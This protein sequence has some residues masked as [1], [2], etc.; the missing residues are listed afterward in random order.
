MKKTISFFLVFIMTLGLFLNFFSSEAL[1]ANWDAWSEW[2]DN[3]VAGNSS[4][5]VETRPVVVGYNMVVYQTQEAAPPY[6]RNF[7]SFSVNGNY[8]AYGLRSSYQE[9]HW[10]TYF[11]KSYLD[12]ARKYY[13]GDYINIKPEAYGY[14]RDNATSYLDSNTG[15]PWFIQ[16]EDVKTQYRFRDL[17]VATTYTVIFYD[18]DGK[19]LKTQ[20]VEQGQSAL[21][22]TNPYRE[23]YTFTGWNTSYSN[24]QSN[25]NVYAQYT[26]NSKKQ[27]SVTFLDWDGS[28]L[29]TQV[30]E[31][32]QS[33]LPPTN[34]YREG[35][36]FTGWSTPYSNVQSNTN[37]Y[38]QYAENSKKQFTVTFLDWDRSVLKTQVVEQGQSALPPTNPYREGYTFTGWSTSYSNVLSD[39]IIY[40]RY[41]QNKQLRALF[42]PTV[43][44]FSF[45][46]SRTDLGFP[47]G[48]K[49]PLQLWIDVHGNVNGT[50]L[51]YTRGQ[52]IWGGSCFGF[53][54]ASEKFYN[55][56][57][58]PVSYGSQKTFDISAPRSQNH[59]VTQ[60]IERSQISWFLP[61]VAYV[62]FN[63]SSLISACENFA[64]SGNNPLILYIDAYA[65]SIEYCHAVVPWKV[66]H[67]GND[68]RIYIYDNN[69]PG[70]ENIY[71]TAHANGQ[72]SCNYKYSGNAITV[73]RLGYIRL[74][75]VL[76]GESSA[77]K[78]CMLISVDMAAAQIFSENGTL[79]D[80]LPD[81]QKIEP[82]P[83]AE[84]DKATDIT[85]YWLPIN[86]YIVKTYSGEPVSITVAD[87]NEA[88]SLNLLPSISGMSVDIGEQLVLTDVTHGN[89]TE[90]K[91]DGNAD[92]M[93]IL[94]VA[95]TSEMP[96]STGTNKVNFDDVSPESWF[97]TAVVSIARS[98]IINGVGNNRFDPQGTLTVAEL[99]TMLMR[100]RYGNISSSNE[101]YTTYIERAQRDGILF[102]SDNLSPLSQI[103]R[104]QAAQ[105]LS[106]YIEKFNS[107]W[108]KTRID[109]IPIDIE[110]VPS[111]YRNAVEKAY[112]WSVIQGDNN[113]MFNPQN[114]LSRAEA[115]Q[116]LYNYFSIVD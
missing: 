62:N 70:N 97:N 66:E 80:N 3:Y 109:K 41:E 19:T 28:V 115:A 59:Q 108:V 42:R 40:A 86:E 114:T 34:P 7:R 21:P 78:N 105:I 111:N 4:R 75:Q 22:P 56:I 98:G 107:R 20:V 6:Y 25:T 91:D 55:K 92:V 18:W 51:F 32:G 106:R 16:S 33:A 17:I 60:L 44:G 1:A 96:R 76:D 13:N 81:A 77:P 83:S 49:T 73:E 87:G 35:Y 95:G 37:V 69:Q 100:T 39:M 110:S 46:N 36:T 14:Q 31:Q 38:A 43:D 52:D 57:I 72:Y 99:I 79:V 85:A 74:Q 8:G 64:N 23:G 113:G 71:F 10:T 94:V 50:A 54:V 5:Q 24:V 102:D 26:E 93:P 45:L 12:N 104:A 9:F 84:S 58:N 89:V 101:W 82:I 103:T 48:Y 112:T 29:K 88:Y 90:Y 68:T 65:G 53:S 47:N 116:L 63:R 61:G 67:F 15:I 30:V 2:Q 11:P 27:F